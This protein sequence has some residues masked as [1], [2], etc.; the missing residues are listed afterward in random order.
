MFLAVRILILNKNYGEAG[1]N[2]TRHFISTLTFD[3]VSWSACSIAH[4]IFASQPLPYCQ[5][6][7]YSIAYPRRTD[8]SVPGRNDPRAEG[9]M[10]SGRISMRGFGPNYNSRV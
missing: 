6:Y 2:S 9:A 4:D 10:R 7:Y 1:N 8:L 5:Y 3:L